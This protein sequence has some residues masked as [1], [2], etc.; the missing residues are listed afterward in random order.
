MTI[1]RRIRIVND[2]T[3]EN[4]REWDNVGT[5]ICFHSRYSLGD[6]ST[7]L[8]PSDWLESLALGADSK[9]ENRLERLS[10]QES[11]DAAIWVVLEKH[12]FFLPLYLYDHSGITM[13]TSGFSCGWDS[14]QVGWIYVPKEI[15]KNEYGITRFTKKQVERVERLL[16]NEV[17]VY[18]Q[19]L[20]G[21]VHGFI[22][23]EWKTHCEHCEDGDWEEVESCYGF[24]GNDLKENGMSDHW[25]EDFENVEIIYEA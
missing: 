11:V 14:G 24:Y 17:E 16:K 19:F 10:E 8:S 25:P 18:D 2:D 20:R 6:G 7:N 1:K 13:N 5:M 12:F 15:A 23:E 3:P 21:D 22:C 4:P 9:L